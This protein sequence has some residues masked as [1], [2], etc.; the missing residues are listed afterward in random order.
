MVTTNE[1]TPLV[2]RHGSSS[3]VDGGVEAFHA[4]NRSLSSSLAASYR[5]VVDA[6][7]SLPGTSASIRDFGGSATIASEVINMSKNLIGGGVLS[8]SGGIALCADSPEAVLPAALWILGLGAV[9]GYFCW[10]VGKLC[11]F[12]YQVTYREIWMDTVGETGAMAVPFVNA[13][14]A[15]LGNLA[16]SAILSQTAVSL[17]ESAGFEASRVVCLVFITT[18]MILP[19]CL[20]KSL[21][22][23]APLSALGTTGIMLTAIAMTIRYLDGSYQPGGR[24]HDSLDPKYVPQFGRENGAWGLGILPMACMAFE[25]YVSKYSAR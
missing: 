22:V 11:R 9:F 25:A 15:A 8:L 5:S 10:L 24:F 16:Y 21:N 3:E 23:L 6:T 1:K 7:F 19:L 13:F 14:K 2:V 18:T 4:M 12:T 17:C 20:L